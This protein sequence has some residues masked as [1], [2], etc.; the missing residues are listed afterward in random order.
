MSH[1]AKIGLNSKVIWVGGLDNDKLKNASGVE[2]EQVGIQELTRIHGWPLWVQCSYNTRG[3]KYYNNDGTLGDQTKAL[4]GN[5]PGIGYIWD[6]DNNIF[7]PKQPYA[8]W[9]LDVPTASWVAPVAYPTVTSST[10]NGV[11][12]PYM[13]NWNETTK[14]W[15]ATQV[16]NNVTTNYTWNASTLAWVAA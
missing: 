4:R 1:F 5:Y 12:T 3:G 10:A 11:T 8:S 16:I 14:A 13:I 2:D 7:Y 9:T 15:N 6:E